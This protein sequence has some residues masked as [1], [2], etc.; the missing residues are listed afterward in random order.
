MLLRTLN[1]LKYF[2]LHVSHRS[3]DFHEHFIHL[4]LL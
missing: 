3:V 1:I 2:L 4:N